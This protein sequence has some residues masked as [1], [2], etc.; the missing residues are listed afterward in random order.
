M[1]NLFGA[2]TNLAGLARRYYWAAPLV[3][4]FAISIGLLEGA[5]VSLL[6]PFLAI[7]TEGASGVRGGV[8][9]SIERLAEGYSRNERLLVLLVVFLLCVLLKS[10]LQGLANAFSSWVD[11]RVGQDIRCALSNRLQSVGFPFFL[12]N[13][14]GRLI[15]IFSTESWK[16]SDAIRV[17]L[18][19]IAA[20]ATVVV[21]GILLFV[22]SWRLALVVLA[23]G[24]M[25]RAVQNLVELRLRT[26]SGQTISANQ[27]LADRMLF[28]V[29]QSRII[30]LFHHQQAERDLF[31]Q[32][33]DDVRR[34]IFRVECISGVL[35]PLLEAMHGVLFLIVLLVAVRTHIFLP[36]LAA[37]LVLMI[38]LQ[39][40]LRSLEQSEAA[41]A[42]AAGEL[43][44]VEWLL[45]G[46]DKPNQ[47][48][49]EVEFREFRDA[50]EFDGVS[51]AYAGRA[52]DPALSQV[53]FSLRCGRSTA[54]IGGSGAGKSTVVNLLCRLLDPASGTIRVDGRP[55]STI[56]VGDW[57][58]LIAIAGQD[59]D[60]IDGTIGENIAFGRPGMGQQRIRDA[61]EA[62]YS[63]FMDEFPDG[64]E[65]LVS[66]RGLSLSVGQRQRLGIAR[67][68]ARAPQILILDEAT[69]ALDHEAEAAI[70]RTLS[71]L[72]K[73]MTIL[74]I[75]HRPGTLA[76]CDDAVVLDHGC[77]IETGPM[78]TCAAYRAMHTA[79]TGPVPDGQLTS[80]NASPGITS[81]RQSATEPLEISSLP[82]L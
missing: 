55:L 79:D 66:S 22:V 73:P 25:A 14:P 19:R 12:E 13:D 44:E 23:G 61:I 53:T 63:G 7:L 45:D 60:L 49:G 1:M 80:P 72:P 16:T 10:T 33:S 54:L 56:K 28:A 78:E 68:L 51:L 9:G 18:T 47:P 75:S 40:H 6:I 70:L 46:N 58:N 27:L 48:M 37:F 39:P 20:S 81:S 24:I 2:N 77:V 59:F 64:L 34:A 29:F 82:S 74:T 4:C 17:V 71:H 21:F 36:V 62:V 41:F 76:F 69:N 15:N 35:W 65:T 31:E 3:A 67:A 26:L 57:L 5:G 42:A 43:R 8:V 32:R 30:R 11:G 52:G 38:R 50:I